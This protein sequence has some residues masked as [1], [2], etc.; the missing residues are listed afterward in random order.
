M[1]LPHSGKPQV[2]PL[3]GKKALW[4]LNSKLEARN[5]KQIRMTKIRNI[6]QKL[7]YVQHTKKLA[8]LRLFRPIFD[9]V[10]VI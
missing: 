4:K 5:P 6:K 8:I 7:G 2:A 9:F 1:L 10:F 3:K